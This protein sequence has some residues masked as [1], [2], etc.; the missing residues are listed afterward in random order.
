M[1]DTITL[2]SC[3]LF[4]QAFASRS[5]AAIPFRSVPS[6]RELTQLPRQ[7]ARYSHFGMLWTISPH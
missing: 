6:Y 5:G 4:N 2:H 7:I 3:R 1:I